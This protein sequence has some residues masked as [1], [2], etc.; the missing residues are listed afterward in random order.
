M[1]YSL[2]LDNSVGLIIKQIN[3]QYLYIE[4]SIL[5]INLQACFVCLIIHRNMHWFL[6]VKMIQLV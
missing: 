3:Q 1:L 2:D 4:W 5:N 6:F